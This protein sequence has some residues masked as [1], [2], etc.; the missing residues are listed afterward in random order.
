[1]AKYERLWRHIFFNYAPHSA[2]FARGSAYIDDI[3]IG[4]YHTAR[5]SPFYKGRAMA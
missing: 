5:A 4:W 2:C 1:M 3:V